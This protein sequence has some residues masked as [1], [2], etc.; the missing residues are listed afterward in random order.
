MSVFV[1]LPP[2]IFELCTTTNMEIENETS[3]NDAREAGD[4][5]QLE[6]F[7]KLLIR[8][9]NELSKGSE[10]SI[11]PTW[12]KQDDPSQSFDQKLKHRKLTAHCFTEDKNK[13]SCTCTSKCQHKDQSET[14][15]EFHASST[16]EDWPLKRFGNK[17]GKT[18]PFETLH[19]F[20]APKII[21][22]RELQA[23][24]NFHISNLT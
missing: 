13:K 14:P 3:T 6:L 8:K 18:F 7:A 10:G 5:P 2:N 4:G 24:K 19:R 15:K 17:T 12:I 9:G 20:L 21:K 16:M 22:Q 23:R 11:I 1:M